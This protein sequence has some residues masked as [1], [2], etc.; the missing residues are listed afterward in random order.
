MLENLTD[1]NLNLHKP[2]KPFR[3]NILHLKLCDIGLMPEFDHDVS[4]PKRR[5]RMF[6]QTLNYVLK[7]K[8]YAKLKSNILNDIDC[9]Q[10]LKLKFLDLQ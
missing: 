1:Q 3:Y 5:L 10:A 2:K 9:S 8:S 7:E 6:V 4:L